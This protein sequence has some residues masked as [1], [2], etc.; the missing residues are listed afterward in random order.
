MVGLG[1]DWGILNL[2]DSQVIGDGQTVLTAFYDRLV[3]NDNGKLVPYL[4]KS[5]TTTPTTITFNLT[6][7]ATCSDGTPVTATLVKNSFQPFFQSPTGKRVLGAGPFTVNADDANHTITFTS[8]TPNVDAIFG[9][10]EPQAG[11]VCPPGLVNSRV[12]QAQQAFG[13]GPFT[14]VSNLHGDSLTAKLRSGWKWGPAGTNASTLPDTLI[15]KVVSNMTTA[16]NLLVTGGL[17]VALISGAEVQR[18]K[19]EKSLTLHQAHSFYLF[20]LIINQLPGHSGS[21]Q[22][23]RQAIITAFDPAV[24]N[25]AAQGGNY[26]TGTTFLTKDAQCYDP[27]GGKLAPKHSVAAAQQVLKDAGYVLG[28]NGK[29]TKNGRPLTLTVLAS[30]EGSGPDYTATTLNSVGFTVTLNVPDPAVYGAEA[31]KLNFDIFVQSRTSSAF[32]SVLQAMAFDLGT[33]LPTEGGTN[34][35]TILDPQITALYQA[36]VQSPTVAAK[37][38]NINQ[39]QMLLWKNWDLEP[40]AAGTYDWFSKGWKVSPATNRLEAW[41]LTRAGS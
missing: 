12:V 34:Y 25:Q 35:G 36:A 8:P 24:W 16:A 26:I 37:C 28:S 41:S 2:S 40:V 33:K 17:N 38:N 29:F 18:M 22:A 23:V 5:W 4:A 31:T 15:F 6:P 13:S 27:T 10:S 20:P 7:T 1:G 11:I 14:I 39:I 32:S 19:A 30:P 3:A 21:D 9:F